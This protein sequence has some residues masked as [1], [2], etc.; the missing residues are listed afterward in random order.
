MKD[1]L[2]FRGTKESDFSRIRKIALEGWLFSYGY[3]P[4]EE[5]TKL[6]NKYYSENNLTKSLKRVKRGT[7][8]FVV[9]ELRK[10]VIGFCH[11]AIRGSKGEILRLYLDKDYIR[12]GIGKKLLLKGEHFLKSKQCRKCFTFVNM[13]NKIGS[14]FYIRNKFKHIKEKDKEDESKTGKVL[15]YMEKE[16]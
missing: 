13:H 9:A 7:D 8:M 12:K 1:N 11:I 5:L 14:D 4:K 16:L 3:L 2:K 10:E 6:V 15:W